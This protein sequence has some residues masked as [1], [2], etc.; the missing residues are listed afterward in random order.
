MCNADVM[1]DAEP[2][3]DQLYHTAGDINIADIVVLCRQILSR[4]PA[5]DEPI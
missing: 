4:A 3:V 2:V 5:V 1:T